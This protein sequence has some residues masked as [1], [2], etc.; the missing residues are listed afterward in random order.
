MIH[1]AFFG[2]RL[3]LLNVG[4]IAFCFMF[5][6]LNPVAFAM[7]VVEAT[8]FAAPAGMIL[9]LVAHLSRHLPRLV[10]HSLLVMPALVLV[11]WIARRFGMS[12]LVPFAAV[13][14]FI[15]CLVLERYTRDE[16]ALLPRA[17]AQ[18]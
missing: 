2:L 9:G 10:R 15:S 1:G 8:P 16:P 3:A 6:F 14:T 13:P 5:M 18:R 7:V 12:E 17:V 4:F 11:S